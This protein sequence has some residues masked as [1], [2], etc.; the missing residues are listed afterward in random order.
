MKTPQKSSLPPTVS[1]TELKSESSIFETKSPP[2]ITSPNQ[3]KNDEVSHDVSEISN[4]SI[5]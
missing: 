4:V 1:D 2:A 5:L 3:Q